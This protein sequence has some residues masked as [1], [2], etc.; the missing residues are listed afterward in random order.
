[1]YGQTL[2]KRKDKDTEN[3]TLRMPNV[4]C[5]HPD[6]FSTKGNG[7]MVEVFVTAPWP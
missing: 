5:I 7:E 4:R 6:D 3:D 2:I 1:M